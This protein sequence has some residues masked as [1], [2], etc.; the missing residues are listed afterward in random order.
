M[1]DQHDERNEQDPTLPAEGWREAYEAELRAMLERVA[2]PGVGVTVFTVGEVLL[3]EGY[4][5]RD[6]SGAPVTPDTIFGV[7][8]VTK[9]FTALAVLCLV[10][11]G[12]VSLDDPITKYYEFELWQESSVPTVRHFL[13]HTSGLPPTPTMTWLRY[14][15]QDGDPVAEGVTRELAS[16]TVDGRDEELAARAAEVATFDGL[17]AWLNANVKPLGRAGEVFSYSNDGFCL[18]G[19]LVEK[20]TGVGFDEFVT[21]R[22]L[23]PLGMTRSTFDLQ[24]VLADPDHSE[25]YA[26]DGGGVPQPSPLWETTGRMLGGGMLKSTLTDLRAWV[27]FLMEPER[28]ADALKVSPQLVR[29]MAHPTT[30]AGSVPGYGFGLEHMGKRE[31]EGPEAFA[32]V[33]H[34]GS[35]KGVASMIEW[36]PELGVGAV[37]L[38]NLTGVP[39]LKAATMAFNAYVGLP[40]GTPSYVPG[41]F[42]GTPAERREFLDGLVG[43]YRSGEPYGRVRLYLTPD[44]EL[45]AEVSVPP[46]DL[47]ARLVSRDELALFFPEYAV[48]VPIMRRSDGSVWAVHQGLRVLT[49]QGQ[50]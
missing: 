29:E 2:A 39:S 38:C 6:E 41:D 13:S 14:A 26:R 37:V 35:L 33:G 40:A 17:V 46:V 20:V 1:A 49:R 45:G 44:G 19:G 18:M 5:S 21:E 16:I 15:S 25:L 24:A 12:L 11:D 32:L 10:S 3:E 23:E 42:D 48:P 8:S 27:R 4:G 50:D 7:A 43:E 47:P 22:I 9:S 34:G 30:S 36:S 28:G 31:G